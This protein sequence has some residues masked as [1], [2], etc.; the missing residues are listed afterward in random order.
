MYLTA[1]PLRPI[2]ASEGREGLPLI[3]VP[4]YALLERMRSRLAYQEFA[5][6]ALPQMSSC[7]AG[8]HLSIDSTFE[9]HFPPPFCQK[10]RCSMKHDPIRIEDTSA[11]LSSEK[12]KT[13]PLKG[14]GA[15]W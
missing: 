3:V 4:D 2:A 6:R 13:I 10:A 15:S 12:A 1:L 14:A 9:H 7:G 8:K 5:A 11:W